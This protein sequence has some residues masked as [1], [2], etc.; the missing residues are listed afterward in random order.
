MK[1]VTLYTKPGC[2]LCEAVE[3]VISQVRRGVPFQFISRNIEEDHALFERFKH[4]IPVVE[5][6]GAE[7]ARHRLDAVT[8]LAALS[9]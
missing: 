7:V 9:R 6:E 5:V 8:L 3:Q 4:D 1:T 2:H